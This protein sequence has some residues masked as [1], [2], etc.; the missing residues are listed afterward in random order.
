MGELESALAAGF[1]RRAAAAVED[2]AREDVV[3]A[4]AAGETDPWSGAEL[5]LAAGLPPAE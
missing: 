3:R 5:L 1:R 4:V 2:A